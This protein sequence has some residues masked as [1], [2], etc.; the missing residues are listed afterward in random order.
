MSVCALGGA[1]ILPSNR[2]E[3]GSRGRGEFPKTG[4]ERFGAAFLDRL[5]GASLNAQILQQI[6]LIDTPGVISGT[7]K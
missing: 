2:E 4:L 1:L 3:T 7:R 6:T 5:I